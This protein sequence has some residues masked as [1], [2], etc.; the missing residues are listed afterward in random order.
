MT[1]GYEA[2]LEELAAAAGTFTQEGR[3]LQ[4]VAKGLPQG[5]P[6]TGDGG[7]NA[8]LNA[9][10]DAAQLLGE[11]LAAQVSGHGGKLE[12]AHESYGRSDAGNR[13]LFTDLMK[14]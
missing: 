4:G 10:V 5:G 6:D 3:S 8:A 9:V 13:R 12:A 14:K 7:L 2:M 11:A 1:A